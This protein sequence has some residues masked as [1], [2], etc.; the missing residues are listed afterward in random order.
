MAISVKNEQVDT[1]LSSMGK[2]FKIKSGY[3]KVY[4]GLHITSIREERT[5][6]IDQTR[7][8][9]SKLKKYGFDKC[10]P[11]IVPAD[12][13]YV[14]ELSIHMTDGSERDTEFSYARYSSDIPYNKQLISINPK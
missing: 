10:S 6:H 9:L 1:I 8:I 12:P 2:A 4:V 14:I 11:L 7:Y 13:N 3:P 5:I